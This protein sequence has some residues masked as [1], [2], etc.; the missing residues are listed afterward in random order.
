MVLWYRITIYYPKRNYIGGSVSILSPKPFQRM[1]PE[2]CHAFTCS[3]FCEQCRL[4]EFRNI[5]DACFRV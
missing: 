5:E 4:E 3:S 2:V 1:M